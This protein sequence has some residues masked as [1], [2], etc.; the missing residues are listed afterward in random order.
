MGRGLACCPAPSAGADQVPAALFLVDRHALALGLQVS[1]DTGLDQLVTAAHR[2]A[3]EIGVF[4]GVHL[5]QRQDESGAVA[6]LG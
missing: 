6:I 2:S 4:D 5:G 1:G 3:R